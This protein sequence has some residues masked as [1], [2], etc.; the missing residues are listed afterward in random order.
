MLFFNSFISISQ[1]AKI[2]NTKNLFYKIFINS[3]S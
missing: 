3:H 1:T 2:V